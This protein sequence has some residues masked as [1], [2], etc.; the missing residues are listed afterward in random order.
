MNFDFDF[1]Q[2]NLV[3]VGMGLVALDVLMNGNPN[4][5]IGLYAGGSCGNVM[6]I[7]SFLNWKTY[8]VARLRDNEAGEIVV[9]DLEWAGVDVTFISRLKDGS[10]PIIIHR[11]LKDKI[12]NPKHR[13]EFRDP[14]GGKYLPSY[15][16]VLSSS[17]DNMVND[18]PEANVFYLDRVNRA[19]I[20]MARIHREKGSFIFFEP[21][22]FKDEKQYHECISHAHVVKFSKDRIP[23]YHELFPVCQRELEIMTMG[24]EGL[25]YRLKYQSTW[26]HM[27]SFNIAHLVDAA[28]SGDWCTAG[29]I[30]SLFSNADNDFNTS[31]IEISLTIGQALG[32]LNCCFMGARG[33]MYSMN[34]ESLLKQLGN[35]VSTLDESNFDAI[36]TNSKLENRTSMS[37]QE[38]IG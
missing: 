11:I 1:K 36:F 13:F 24:S 34:K 32:A 25:A 33:I 31:D 18:L 38:L 17:V 21:S 23:D 10:T 16:P 2:R 15:K 28:G 4:T 3:S 9:R 8:P 6:A 7:L 20:E 30:C 5:P 29:I 14:Q 37:L 27:P 26:V 35:I 22:G 12:G 19:G